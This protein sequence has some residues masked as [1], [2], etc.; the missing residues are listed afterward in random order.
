M[1]ER[2]VD[3]DFL[4]DEHIV[5]VENECIRLGVNLALGGAITYLAAHGKKN[6][7]NSYDWGRQVQLSFYGLPRPYRPAGVEISSDWAHG[8][9]NPI[10][11]GDAF[12]NRSQMLE[13]TV[14]ETSVYVKCRPMLWPLNNVPAE[15]TFETWYRLNGAQVEVTSR[16]NNARSDT[17]RYPATGQELPAVYTNGEWWKAVTYVGN[18]PCTGDALTVPYTLETEC[19]PP[20]RLFATEH[21][22]ALVNNEDCGLGIWM[23][24]TTQFSTGSYESDGTGGPKDNPTAY[25]SPHHEEI[26]D[27]DIQYSFD[28]VLIVGTVEEIRAA[29]VARE[30]ARTD[31]YS[32]RFDGCRGHFWYKGITDAGIPGKNGCLDFA[33]AAGNVLVAPPQHIPAGKSRLVLDAAIE[34]DA[35]V[36]VRRTVYSGEF[37][38]NSNRGLPP[39]EE[40]TVVE[41]AGR[42]TGNGERREYTLSL[43]LPV[44][45]IGFEVEFG[46][47]GHARIWSIRVE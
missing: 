31:L 33:F 20:R 36:R 4:D 28:Y 21:W 19:W 27:H 2:F 45:S 43:G 35:P 39:E 18:T 47:A 14:G 24:S 32:W 30:K 34:G 41:A 46:G 11:C 25:I 42:L 44:N 40:K 1:Y 7:I 9:W 6:L 13:Y 17:T 38:N 22:S 8:A 5:Y 3:L 23:P 15:C 10:S 37:H 29:A 12:G 16:I 26:L